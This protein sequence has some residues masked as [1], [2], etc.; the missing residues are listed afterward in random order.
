M[1]EIC[2]VGA[3]GRMGQR[4]TAAVA[5]SGDT[6]LSGAVEA[7][8]HPS[9][10]RDAGE[11]AGLSSLGVKVTDDLDSALSHA[12][13]VIDFS[14]PA[15][16]I[17]T[18]ELCQARG[19]PLVSGVTGIP[20]NGAQILRQAA[21]KIAL[22]WA[23]N[24]SVGVNLMFKIAAQVSSV[25]GDDFDVEIYETHHR[26]KQ[27]APSG[28]AKRLAE[29]IAKSLGRNLEEVACYG[30]IGITGERDSKQIAIHSIRAGDVVGEHTVVFG[31]LGERFEITHK[32]HS[33][34]TFARG[35]VVAARFAATARPGL[36]DMQDVLGL[37]T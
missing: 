15:S 29:V 37:K 34:D 2:L 25:L 8:G 22:V 11:A 20:E 18:V 23:P 30:R 7:K 6:R 36:Y 31:G 27:D 26:F 32:A 24:M 19:I 10:G 5:Q 35:A 12:G 33:R 17:H 28:T 4:I 3:C 1:I 13:V 14:L 21:S 16:L 9:L